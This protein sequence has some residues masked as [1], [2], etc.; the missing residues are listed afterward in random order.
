MR[1]LQLAPLSTDAFKPFGEVI[2]S[3]VPCE[4]IAINEGNTLRH[5]ALAQVDCAEADGSAAIS[6]FR[7]QPIDSSFVLRFM[8]R[9][10]LGSQ[11]FINT[12][13]NPYVIVVA[14]PGDL[15]ET[16]IRGFIAKPS[17]GVSYRRGTWHH[18]LMAL[19]KPSD[20]VVVDRV[21]PGN[22]CDE[23]TLSEPIQLVLTP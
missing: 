16:A 10:P 7:A 19:Q 11:A 5:H 20:F 14:P 15:D 6:L 12:G 13:G 2:D 8:E 21:G 3:E 18:Y 1:E 9:H 17:Q 22:N 23:Q 4:K